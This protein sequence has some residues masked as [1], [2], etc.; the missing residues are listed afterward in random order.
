MQM[1]HCGRMAWPEVNPAGRSIGPSALTPKQT[2]PLTGQ[3]YP[4]PDVMSQFD[5]EHVIEGFRETARG[6]VAAGF[7]GVEIHGA[8]GYLISQFLSAYSN[9]R[10]DD[11]GGSVANRYRFAHEVIEAVR[12][13]VPADRLLTFRVSDWGVADPEVSLFGTREDWQ[14][15]IDLL[16]AES[17]WTPFRSP[18]TATGPTRA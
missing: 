11:Y 13:A 14:Q 8:H 5:I 17:P 1:F 12:P 4:V 10:D 3:P 7:D 15:V 18:A 2:N 6:A 16:D 9:R